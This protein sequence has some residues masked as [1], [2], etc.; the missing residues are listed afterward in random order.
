MSEPLA[1][2]SSP[3]QAPGGRI[4]H[5]FF[6][7]KGG[8]STGIY[9]SLNTGLGSGDDAATVHKNRQRV[10]EE[11]DANGAFL[12]TPHQTHSPDA[13]CVEAAWQEGVRPRADAVVTAQP[14]IVLGILTAD[15]GPVLFADDSAGVVGAAHAG[16]RGAFSGVLENTVLAMEKLGA[17][18]SNIR[19][20]LGPTISQA[21]YE[22]GPEFVERAQTEDDGNA[23]WFKSS[24]RDGHALFDL[25]GYICNRLRQAGVETD[26]T[27]HCTYDHE[28]RFFSYRRTTHRGEPDYGRQISAIVLRQQ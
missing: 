25:P 18:R 17:A 13:I 3:L 8:S 22:V 28:D 6:T 5:G 26:W 15:C 4:G 14:G 21:N 11:L 19:A 1:I 9:A 23:R 7:R 16:W 20:A 12:A 2:T 27:G 24:L 10:L